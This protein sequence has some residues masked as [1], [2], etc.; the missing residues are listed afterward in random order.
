MSPAVSASAVASVL[1]AV[2]VED[3]SHAFS[4]AA[5]R[6]RTDLLRVRLRLASTKMGGAAARPVDLDD[7]GRVAEKYRPRRTDT[8]DSV[9][10]SRESVG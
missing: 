6:I 5:T 2:T 8:E 4:V 7:L 10:L 1:L 3:D 9:G